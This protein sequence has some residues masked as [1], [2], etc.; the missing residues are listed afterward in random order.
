[1]G[2]IL[3]K[4][5]KTTHAIREAIQR[6]EASIAS[7][8]REYKLNY[9]TVAKWKKRDTVDDAPMG[10]KRVH[11]V[12]TPHEEEIICAFRRK[13]EFPLDDCYIS[14]KEII[15][16]LSR[17]N[18]HRCLKRHGLNRLPKEKKSTPRFC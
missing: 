6:S 2:Q 9:K 13:T 8:A 4:R 5:A 17:S 16:K 12:L 18:L 15:P 3:H 7:L 11:T 14:L 10:A 1:M